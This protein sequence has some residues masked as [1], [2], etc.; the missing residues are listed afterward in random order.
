MYVAVVLDAWSHGVVGRAMETHLR[1]ELVEKALA[2]AI[3]RRH[4]G[5]STQY[6][7]H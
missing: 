3:I 2:M 7:D 5:S 1:S 6:P 4:L